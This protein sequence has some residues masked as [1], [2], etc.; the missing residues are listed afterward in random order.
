MRHVEESGFYTTLDGEHTIVTLTPSNHGKSPD[1]KQ[2]FTIP[3]V[4]KP[5]LLPLL[6][7]NS[8]SI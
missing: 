7:S 2:A 4:Q 8:I 1:E 3:K 5:N 6:F